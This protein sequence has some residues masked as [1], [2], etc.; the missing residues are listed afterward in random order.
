MSSRTSEA[1][2]TPQGIPLEVVEDVEAALSADRFAYFPTWNKSFFNLDVNLGNR[3]SAEAVEAAWDLAVTT[4]PAGAVACVA[5]W[6]TDF[7]AD[8]D[9]I[10]IPVLVL[11]GSADR[12]LPIEACGVTHQRCRGE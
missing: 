12:I 8:L 2:A 1:P 3:V 5:T 7:R 4:S 6:R 10:D 9:K 11:H